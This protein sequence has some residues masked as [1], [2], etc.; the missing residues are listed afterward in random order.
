MRGLVQRKYDQEN[1]SPLKINVRACYAWVEALDGQRSLAVI[2]VDL[3]V[4]RSPDGSRYV[5]ALTVLSVYLD[6]LSQKVW[7]IH[8][9]RRMRKFRRGK[10][11][12]GTFRI[13]MTEKRAIDAQDGGVVEHTLCSF[14]PGE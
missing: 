2:K 8:N 12:Y 5:K 4:I 14:R 1:T 3:P 10:K 6:P 7:S 9:G 13:F 11:L